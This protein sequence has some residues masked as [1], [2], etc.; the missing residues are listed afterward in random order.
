MNENDKAAEQPQDQRPGPRESGQQGEELPLAGLPLGGPGI[1][2]QVRSFGP[3]S[4]AIGI[5]LVILGAVGIVVP[6]L[7][8]IMTLGWV[9]ALLMVG[10]GFWVYHTFKSHSGGLMDW[11]KPLLLIIT[12]GLM[13]LFPLPGVASLAVL[14][15][16][17]FLMDAIGSYSLAHDRYPHQGWMWM[18]FNGTIDLVLAFLFM[19][20]WPETSLWMVGLFVGVSLLFD[21][22]A[23]IMIGWALRKGTSHA[24]DTAGSAATKVET[25]DRQTRR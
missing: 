22:W 4:M 8:S 25:R 9:S 6:A 1:A 7:M 17:Y 13:L 2:R 10:G 3:H 23:L 12:G 18:A 5:L 14:L 20:G 19:I 16:V 11:L 21:G 24:G 15:T